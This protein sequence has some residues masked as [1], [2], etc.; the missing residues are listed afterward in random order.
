MKTQKKR[1]SI[2]WK[3]FYGQIECKFFPHDVLDKIMDGYDFG[4]SIQ[5]M[6]IVEDI[7]NRHKSKIQQ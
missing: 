2:D 6:E 4:N 7:I 3:Y 1:D 5:D